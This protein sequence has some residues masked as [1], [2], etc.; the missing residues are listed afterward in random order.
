MTSARTH[1]IWCLLAFIG[2]VTACAVLYGWRFGSEAM[3]LALPDSNGYD[4]VG[5]A[6][7]KGRAPPEGLL[8]LRGYFYPMLAT[9]FAAVSPYLL[10]GCQAVGVALGVFCLLRAEQAALGRVLVTPLALLSVSLLLSPASMMTEASSFALAAAALSMFVL[11]PESGWGFLMLVLAALVRPAFLPVTVLAGLLSL[12]FDR[13]SA[14]ALVLAVAVVVP[15]LV[16]T[17]AIDGRAQL[18]SAGRINVDQRFYPAV[19]GMAEHGHFVSYKS[20]EAAAA[21]EARPG[22]DAQ[23]AYMLGQ[24]VAVA[25]TWAW[26]LL[27]R[28]ILEVTGFAAKDNAAANP[29]HAWWLKFTSGILNSILVVAII[30]AVLGTLVFLRQFPVRAWPAA[31]IGPSIIATAVTGAKARALRY[32]RVVE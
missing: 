22:I 10:L 31:L 16:L 9:L 23:I 26:I 32:R 30:P 15:Q 13:A 18:S 21:H 19:F 5:G 8:A 17:H 2:S 20:S 1:L 4:A 25:K 29:E 3:I 12:R 14:R 11:R 24:P 27:H 7:W 6:L 28:H